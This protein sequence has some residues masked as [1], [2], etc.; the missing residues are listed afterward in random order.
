MVSLL[1]I[2]AQEHAVGLNPVLVGESVEVGFEL[3]G[4]THGNLG[5]PAFTFPPGGF[6]GRVIT[7]WVYVRVEAGCVSS[8]R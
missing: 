8:G 2:P 7:R 1:T 5:S 4:Q 3:A 6:D